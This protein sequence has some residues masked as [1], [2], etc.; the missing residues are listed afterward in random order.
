M[1]IKIIKIS[2]KNYQKFGDVFFPRKETKY[3]KV[4]LGLAKR[5]DWLAGVKN[6][7]PK[8]AQLNLS[9]FQSKPLLKTK[10]IL[11]AKKPFQ[12][13][14]FE[15][16]PKST[17]VFIPMPPKDKVVSYMILVCLGKDKPDLK[18][19]QAFLVP[20]SVGISYHPGIWHHTLIVLDHSSNFACLVY[21]DNS[22]E[23][24]VVYKVEEKL[25]F[26]YSN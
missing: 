7:R 24:C 2:Q 20:S 22:S 16:H 25:F 6:L 26:G 10:Q 5:Y 21:E 18:T 14:G 12:I 9:Y 23:D 19:M 17:Q 8:T 11:G 13:K 15:K 3:K 4:N 1:N